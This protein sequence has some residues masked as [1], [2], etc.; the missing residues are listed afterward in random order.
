MYYEE[1]RG[2]ELNSRP[3]AYESPALPLSYLGMAIAVEILLWEHVF[4]N[5]EAI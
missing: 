4:V 3:R 2:G 1:C 5:T